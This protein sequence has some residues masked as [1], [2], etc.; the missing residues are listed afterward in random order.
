[1]EISSAYHLYN[2]VLISIYTG[3]LVFGNSS[4]RRDWQSRDKQ[5][6]EVEDVDISSLAPS[7]P[8]L[9]CPCT[10][11]PLGLHCHPTISSVKPF[12]LSPFAYLPLPLRH[13][14]ALVSPWTGWC[15]AK[16]PGKT[17]TGGQCGTSFSGN[18][19]ESQLFTEYSIVEHLRNTQTIL[20]RR[21]IQRRKLVHCQ[22]RSMQWRRLEW[23]R[24][25]LAKAWPL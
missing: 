10:V 9:R 16:D 3:F 2:A 25:S 17:L 8:C 24:A 21:E 12:P 14:E 23:I 13:V 7:T 15:C 11:S 5:T 18:L 1:M 22:G 19:L 6:L 4:G 20:Y